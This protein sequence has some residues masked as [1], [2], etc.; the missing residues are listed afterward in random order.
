MDYTHVVHSASPSEKRLDHILVS[1]QFDVRRCE[2]WNGERTPVEGLQ[3]S[4]HAPI[5]TELAIE[6]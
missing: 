1:E 4:D 5:V 3:A 6:P 2:I